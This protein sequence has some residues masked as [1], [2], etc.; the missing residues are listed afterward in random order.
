MGT[1]LVFLLGFPSHSDTFV[2]SARQLV[3]QLIQLMLVFLG[4]ATPTTPTPSTATPHPV[5][6]VQP[7]PTIKIEKALPNWMYLR[8]DPVLHRYNY[9]FNGKATL[10]GEHCANAS[11]L[12]RLIAG[13]RTVTKGALTDANGDYSLEVAIDAQDKSPVDWT[14]DAY[15]ADFQKVELSGRQIVQREV[16]LG[17]EPEK[18]PII[19]TNPVEFVV[20]L[21][22]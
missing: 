3:R 8:N 7:K 13:D 15:T 20:S 14:M 4:L 18:Q 9:V 21:S 5:V 16:E 1:F 6:V 11:V 22:K 17:Q 12:I 19:V 2:G 10:H